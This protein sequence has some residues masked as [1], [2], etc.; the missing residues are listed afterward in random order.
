MSEAEIYEIVQDF[1]EATQEVCVQLLGVGIREI[2]KREVEISQIQFDGVVAVVGFSGGFSG[3]FW[4]GVPESF[5]NMLY[6]TMSGHPSSSWEEQILAV[7]EFGNLVAGHALTRVNNRFPGK[8]VRPAPPSSF[9]GERLVFFNF[10]MRGSHVVFET[11]HGHVE[12][13]ILLEENA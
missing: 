7:S 11:P 2:S 4:L 6:G 8:N 9:W 10:G 12:M 5:L 1:I 3:R 13:N